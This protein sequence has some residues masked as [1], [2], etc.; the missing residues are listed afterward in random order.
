MYKDSICYD[1]DEVKG[2]GR[3]REDGEKKKKMS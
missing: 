3:N 1:D 2:M